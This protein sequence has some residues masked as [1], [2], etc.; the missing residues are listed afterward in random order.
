MR[1][2]NFLSH[3]KAIGVLGFCGLADGTIHMV[4]PKL[5][6]THAS[7]FDLS[8]YVANEAIFFVS[9]VVLLIAKRLDILYRRLQSLEGRRQDNA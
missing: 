8:Y 6:E 1:L 2:L 3:P 4:L 9:A 5:V 7:S